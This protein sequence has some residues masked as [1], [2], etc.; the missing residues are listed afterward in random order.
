MHITYLGIDSTTSHTTVSPEMAAS[1]SGRYSRSNEGLQ[2]ILSKIDWENQDK[3]V[4]KIL[5]YV[6]YGHSSLMGLTGSIALFIDGISMYAAYELFRLSPLGAGQE[7]STRYIK[8]GETVS[9][10]ELGINSS[11]DHVA[12]NAFKAYEKCLKFWERHKNYCKFPPNATPKEKARIERNFA[13]DHSRY[14]IPLNAKTNIVLMQNG[15]EWMRVCKYL[16]S[17]NLIELRN[18]GKTILETLTPILPRLAK[19][20]SWD[21]NWARGIYKSSKNRS[22]KASDLP[23]YEDKVK[24]DLS[25]N[26]NEEELVEALEFHADRYAW[27]GEILSL[28]PASFWLSKI[29]MAEL[30]DLNRHRSG[31]RYSNLI[32]KGFY[33][34]T[35]PYD[36]GTLDYEKLLGVGE[37]ISSCALIR[38]T[39]GEPDY[40]Y[41]CLL[42][43]FFDYY[44]TT[45]LDKLIYIIELRTGRGAHFKYSNYMKRVAEEVYKIYPKLRGLIQEGT[46]EPE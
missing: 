19:H 15:Q 31:T 22:K 14:Y 6:D 41:S 36:E 37:E 11:Y 17:S 39:K 10:E 35:N 20:G 45:T 3:S 44:H 27:S 34:P 9:S 28:I 7:S 16:N 21:T 1:V 42:G 30:R 32:P 12:I 33:A 24:L 8:A 40:M 4:D 5:S 43:T 38:L 25:P 2:A 46:A 29:P 18:I 23:S 26:W 13:Y